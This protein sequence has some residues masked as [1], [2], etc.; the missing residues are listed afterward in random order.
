M[1]EA[2]DTNGLKKRDEIIR[3]RKVKFI[4]RYG[5]LYF[6]IPMS[7]FFILFNTFII[8]DILTNPSNLIIKLSITTLISV[9]GGLIA[10]WLYG[11]FMWYSANQKRH[12][13]F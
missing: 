7:I 3:S 8:N 12:S 1:D 5:I 13:D 6:G 10:G 4:M 2:K 9:L 11:S